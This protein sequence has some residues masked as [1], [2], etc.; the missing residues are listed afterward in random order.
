MAWTITGW[1]RADRLYSKGARLMRAGRPGEAA[2]A[3]ADVAALFPKHYRAYLQQARALGA[4][5]RVGEAAQAAKRAAELAPKSHAPMLVLGQ[6][7]YDAGRYEEARK[8]FAA[9]GRLDPE[10]RMVQAYLGLSL[11]AQGRIEE[12]AGLVQE[13][14]LY[15]YDAFEARLL[16]LAESFL[17]KHRDRAR[18]LEEQLTP[19]EGGRDERPA[20]FGLQ[21]ASAVRR[22]VLWPLA[23]LRGRAAAARLLAAEAFSVGEWDKAI[24]AL[25]ESERAGAD[26]ED[27]A[28]SLGMAYL[29]QRKPQAAAEQFLRLPEEMR[30]APDIAMMLGA[31]LFDS[32]RYEEAREPLGTAAEH[33][34]KDFLPAYYRGMCDIALGQPQASTRWFAL[35]VERL[36]PQLAK[37]RLEEMMRVWG[38]A[39][40]A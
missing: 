3:F 32:G 36:N 31:A 35:A 6:I 39:Q 19:D 38:E 24:A 11:L 29:E 8:A 7:Q 13:H 34:T 26:Q 18:S 2:R 28:V 16:T 9:A 22:M 20:G 17:W 25:Q 12:G 14:S 15:A 1:L 27:T 23:R 30:R 4:A 5:G 37:K 33:F 21:F 10:N 40:K